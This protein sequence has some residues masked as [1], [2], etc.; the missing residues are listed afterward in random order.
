MAA[1]TNM[2][3]A[4]GPESKETSKTPYGDR[5]SRA[6]AFTARNDARMW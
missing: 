2:G 4:F 1:D 5:Y 3:N 6:V